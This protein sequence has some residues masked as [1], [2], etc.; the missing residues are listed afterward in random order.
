MDIKERVKKYFRPM[1]FTTLKNYNSKKFLSDLS[2]GVIVGVVALPIS[3]AFAIASGVSPEKGIITAV[4][5][6][7]LISAL[8]GSHVQVGG[9]TGAFIVIVYGIVEQFGIQGL[10]ISTILAGC[11]LIAMGLFKLG[12]IIKFMPYPIIIGFT[13]GIAVVIFS[14]QIQDIFGLVI[15]EDVPSNF[16]EKFIV[17]GKYFHTIN[18]IAVAIAVF[19]ILMIVFMPKINKKI[20]GTLVALIITTLIVYFFKLDV[21]TIGNSG[22]FG[23]IPSKIPAPVIPIISYKTFRMLLLPAFTI[24]MLGAIE[25]LLSAMVADGALGT[26]H[27]SNTELIA[28]GTANIFSGL[29][30]GIPATGA[31]ART[32]TNIR[33]GGKTPVA[34]MIH[35]IVLLLILLFFG[36]QAKLIPLSCLGGILAVV[37]YNMSEWRS[38][39]RLLKNNKLEVGVLVSTFLLTVL[40]DLTMAILFGVVLASVLFIKRTVDTTKIDVLKLEVENENNENEEKRGEKITIPDGVEVFEM[41]G[42]F[43]FGV[44]NIFDEIDKNISSPPKVLIIRFWRVPFVDATAVNNFRNFIIRKQKFG[45]HIIISKANEQVRGEFAKNGIDTL[46]GVENFLPDVHQ[47]INRAN[48]VIDSLNFEKNI[49][50]EKK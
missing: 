29:F 40:V 44:A 19:T 38:F 41:R 3:I 46:I 31:I 25:S 9:P 49:N 14:S 32:M 33:N 12:T 11:M 26:N 6:G 28:Q 45:I 20:P 15:P 2:A 43:F 22:R 36:S 17:F 13:S 48:E 23:E 47:A 27:R 16:V 34:G 21:E 18:W 39:K 30:G 24:S 10:I 7:F 1:L 5:A 42:P 4:I 8:G 50:F 35:A 37:A